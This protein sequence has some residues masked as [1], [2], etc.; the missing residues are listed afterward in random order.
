MHEYNQ[1]HQTRIREALAAS[2]ELSHAAQRLFLSAALACGE[3]SDQKAQASTIHAYARKIEGQMMR[4]AHT[5]Q[6][7][8]IK[9][10]V[11]AH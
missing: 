4:Y 8:P 1:V 10:N 6:D 9:T 5:H 11:E 2:H 3:D 7:A